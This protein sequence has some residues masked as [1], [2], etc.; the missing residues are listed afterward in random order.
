VI[1]SFVGAR[2]GLKCARVNVIGTGINFNVTNV[3]DKGNIGLVKGI[4]E[5][6]KLFLILDSILLITN[7]SEFEPDRL[8]FPALLNHRAAGHNAQPE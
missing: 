5:V 1:E 2:Y 3:N 8:A 7:Y 6:G 4:D